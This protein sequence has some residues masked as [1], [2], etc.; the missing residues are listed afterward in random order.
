M[1]Y[2][3]DPGYRGRGLAKAALGLPARPRP[4]GAGGA[5]RARVGRPVEHRLPPPGPVARASFVI[6]EEID[7][8]DSLELVPL[9]RCVRPADRDRPTPAW[10]CCV[11]TPAPARR[12]WPGPSS[13][14][15][16]G[17]SPGW[18]R[19]S[20][21][22]RSSELRDEKGSPAIDLID[23][24]VRFALDRGRHVVLDGILGS[25][26]YGAMLRCLRR[27]HLGTTTAYV[28]HLPF[29]ET[30]RRHATKPD[31]DFGEAEMR[32]WFNPAPLVPGLEE[33]ILTA[34]RWRSTR[35]LRGS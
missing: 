28:W 5:S 14:V 4:G 7:E 13:T 30:V 6:G 32:S 17:T 21:A 20:C 29:E 22:A 1:G 2:E 23:Q 16:T 19:T 25:T 12:R 3:I 31:S 8:E 26:T 24:T 27:D 33:T 9:A 34:R 18:G 35:Q 10:S 15:A 11:A